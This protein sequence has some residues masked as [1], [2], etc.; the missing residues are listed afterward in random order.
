MVK[1]IIFDLDGTLL[2]TLRDICNVLNGSLKKFGVPCLSLEKI[3]QYVG[4]GARK[5]VERATVGYDSELIDK[6][7]ED[8]RVNFAECANLDTVLYDGETD[9][10]QRAKAKGIKMA[11]VTNKP[12]KACDKV[13][14]QF[15]KENYFD[16][17]IGQSDDFA[18]KPDPSAVNFVIEKFG[19]DKSECLFVGDGDTDVITAKNAGIRCISTLWGFRSQSQLAA[20]GGREFADS[21]ASLGEMINL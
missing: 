5:L 6:I 13:M 17:V 9:F 20:V 10:L 3:I 14:S 7:Y 12:Q 15:F 8:Y 4:N 1:A 2:N 18:L 16:Y 19:V 21:F 11:V